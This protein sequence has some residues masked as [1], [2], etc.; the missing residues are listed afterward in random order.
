M[1]KLL[2][3]VKDGIGWIRFNR[4]EVLNAFNPAECRALVDTLRTAADDKAVKAIIIS[5]VGDVFCAGDDLKVALEE[6]PL[7]KSGKMHPILDI[8]EDITESLQEIPRI[9]RKA[10]K[11]VIAAVRGYAVG[12][13]FEIAIDCDM[14]VAADNATFG[15]PE[16]NAGMT[17]TGGASKL[18]PMIVGLNKARELVLTGEFINAAEGHRIG[19]VNRL[20]PLGQEEAE[21][22]RLAR[23]I[24][25]RAPLA[26]MQ[27][28]RLLQ[29]STEADFETALNLEKQTIATLIYTEDYG[30]AITAFGEKRKPEFKGR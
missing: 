3:E 29:Q 26:V 10:N 28:K 19:L 9:I 16:A 13:G 18:L 22:E 15:F 21:A 12:G 30:E 23:V 25:S 1:T 8:I 17:I 2:Y 11:V 20:V 14:I 4:P 7:I 5:S 27:H 6:Y 24:M